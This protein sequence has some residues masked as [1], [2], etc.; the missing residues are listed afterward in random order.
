M[1]HVPRIFYA[2]AKS[3]ITYNPDAFLMHHLRR[4]LRL[5][6]GTQ[7]RV[8]DGLGHEYA[9]AL[10]LTGKETGQIAIY[11]LIR[12][13]NES[14]LSISLMQA[15]S[16]SNRMDYTIQKAVELGVDEIRPVFSARSVVQLNADQ[17]TRKLAHWKRICISACEQSGRCR[18]PT[19][20]PPQTIAQACHARADDLKFLLDPTANNTLSAYRL[21]T[22]RG[23]ALLV[24][25][26]SGLDQAEVDS[27]RAAGFSAIRLGPRIL[28]TETAGAACLAAIQTLWGD[29]S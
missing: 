6:N 15:I 25:A 28:R 13:E 17:V 16:R 2:Q 24:G 10:Q 21:H 22:P 5:Q 29:F 9:A 19:L 14:K 27:A 8:F 7:L 12:K 1:Q 3:N 23:V 4:V 11:D 26:E 20:A 18:L